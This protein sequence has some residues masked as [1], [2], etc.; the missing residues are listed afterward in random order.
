MWD[1]KEIQDV[2]SDAGFSNIQIYW[3]GVDKN[4]EGDS[5]F[6]PTTKADNCESWV[7]YISARP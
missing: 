3:E 2:L 4:G 6:K 7:T 1:A 5:K